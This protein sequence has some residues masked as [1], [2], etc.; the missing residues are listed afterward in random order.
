MP[1]STSRILL[2]VFLVAIPI[3]LFV[4]FMASTSLDARL[5]SRPGHFYVVS[6]TAL[7]CAALG[8]A[9][10]VATLQ[11]GSVR[12]LLV[13]LSFLSMAGVFAVHGLATPGFLVSSA[14]DEYGLVVGFS[15]RLA[16][17]LA[18]GFLAASAVDW[19]APWPRPSSGSRAG[20]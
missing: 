12:T 6:A 7:I 9:A 8:F 15:A 2:W 3:T 19:H 13:A 1:M 10:S 16:I 5:V 4:A 20:C 18:A 14:N 11:I 17:L